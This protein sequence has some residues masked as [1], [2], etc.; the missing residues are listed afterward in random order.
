MSSWRAPT[1]AAI[2]LAVVGATA[3]AHAESPSDPPAEVITVTPA[4]HVSTP[5]PVHSPSSNGQAMTQ[6]VALTI[7]GGDLELQSDA[8]TVVLHSAES[9]TKWIGDLPP[10]RVV[11]A[12]GT[13]EGWTV[14]WTVDSLEVDGQPRRGTVR[15]TPAD[16]V[17]VAGGEDGLQAGREAVARRQGRVL[18]SADANHGGGTYEAGGQVTVRLP[19]SVHPEAVVVHLSFSVA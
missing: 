11:D 4:P 13:L 2:V 15:V 5:R 16:P 14:E 3:V 17:V 9:G 12:R 8:A 1:V 7:N 10:V 18:F 6:T 19:G